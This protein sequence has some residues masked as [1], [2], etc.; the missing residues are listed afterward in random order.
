MPAFVPLFWR[1][2]NILFIYIYSQNGKDLWI[3]DDF[4]NTFSHGAECIYLSLRKAHDGA[5]PAPLG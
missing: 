5:A 3:S 4:V 2:Y 1:E